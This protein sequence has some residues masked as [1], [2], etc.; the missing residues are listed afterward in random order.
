MTETGGNEVVYYLVNF[1]TISLVQMS[2]R[3]TSAGKGP[4]Q[5]TYNSQR[6]EPPQKKGSVQSVHIWW[7]MYI[8]I[9]TIL[10]IQGLIIN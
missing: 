8:S 3:I 7:Y 5:E 2:A 10:K 1:L 6:Q 4:F 9:N